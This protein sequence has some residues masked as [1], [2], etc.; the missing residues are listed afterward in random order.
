MTEQEQHILVLDC[1]TTGLEDPIDVIEIAWCEVDE[2]LDIKEEFWSLIDPGRS[3]PCDASGICSI[4]DEDV[5]GSPSIDQIRFPAEETVIVCHNIDY[6]YPLVKP[7]M[8]ITGTICTQTLSRRLLPN[9]PNHKLATLSCYCGLP[10]QLNH[11]AYADVRDCLAL[12]DFLMQLT[13]WDLQKMYDFCNTPMRLTHMAW[14][15]HKGTKMEDL[16]S[17]Y[18]WWLTNKATRL[19]L[20]TSFTLKEVYGVEAQGGQRKE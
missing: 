16:P 1:E 6:D 17:G 4:R 15:S 10:R 11:R 2:D 5:L 9:A 19:D 14:G 18:V 8:N 7:Y 3:I 12:L 20:D 13:G